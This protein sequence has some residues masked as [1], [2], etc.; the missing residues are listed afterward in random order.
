MCGVLMRLL[1]ALLCLTAAITATAQDAQLRIGMLIPD[2]II[3]SSNRGHNLFL[4]LELLRKNTDTKLASVNDE[5]QKLSNQ[6]QSPSISEVSKELI[7]K[8]LRDR[9]FESKKLQ[10]DSQIEL[11]QTEQAVVTQFQNEITP[12]VTELAKE[13]KLQLVLQFHPGLIAYVDPVCIFD[14]SN[15]IA[16]RYDAKYKSDIPNV[17]S[18]DTQNKFVPKSMYKP[19]K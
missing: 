11:Q 7:R 2:K 14:F 4:N 3:E 5:I 17:T 8:Q 19:A 13:Q 15:E 18:S 9:D 12:L 1:C 6:L 16:K 10:E